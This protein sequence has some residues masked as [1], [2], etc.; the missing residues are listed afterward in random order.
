MWGG[1]NCVLYRLI[2]WCPTKALQA[3][4]Q[5]FSFTSLGW[6]SVPGTATFVYITLSSFTT[7]EQ[8]HNVCSGKPRGK[9]DH[10]RRPCRNSLSLKRGE[11]IGRTIRRCGGMCTW[12]KH[13]AHLISGV[14]HV[15]PFQLNS[16]CLHMLWGGE[17]DAVRTD[18]FWHDSES[19]ERGT[20]KPN[21]FLLVTEFRLTNCEASEGG[22]NCGYDNTALFSNEYS[23]LQWMERRRRRGHSTQLCCWNGHKQR[24]T[25][26]VWSFCHGAKES[27]RKSEYSLSVGSVPGWY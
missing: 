21:C 20:T 26:S 27:Q 17:G 24:I 16:E 13:W 1:S 10:D 23:A 12:Y 3:H 11:V 5:R 18:S 25:H 8:E 7:G 14:R 6:S 19:R 15:H 2:T 4:L 22:D 9:Q